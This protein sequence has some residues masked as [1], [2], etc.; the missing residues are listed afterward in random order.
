TFSICCNDK[1]TVSGILRSPK[2]QEILEPGL[3]VKE[4]E[5]HR[6]N[7]SE[8]SNSGFDIQEHIDLDTQYARSGKM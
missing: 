5:L 6:R 1:I 4:Y 8:T 2:A 3:K 7:F